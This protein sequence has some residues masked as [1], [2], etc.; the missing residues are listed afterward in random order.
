MDWAVIGALLRHLLTF[1]GGFLVTD[2][3]LTEPDLQTGI[4]AVIALGGVIWSIVQKR[5]G[6]KA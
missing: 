6:V 4:G 3:V 1:G 5:G 2:G